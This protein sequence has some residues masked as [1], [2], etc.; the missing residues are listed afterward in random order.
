MASGINNTFRQV[1]IA[2]GTA[3]LGA[4][5]QHVVTQRTT[6]ALAGVPGM[7]GER[8]A[9]IGRAFAAGQ[10]GEV[11][12]R[13]PAGARDAVRH[14]FA[15]SFTSGLNHILVIGAIVCFAGA[16]C[17]LALVRSRDFVAGAPAAAAA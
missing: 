12:A 14:A 17:A 4:I 7:T 3:A 15:A 13:A 2:T 10:G 6:E 9:A 16:A 5:F 1:G 11:A 8:V